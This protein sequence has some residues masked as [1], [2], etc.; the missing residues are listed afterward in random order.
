MAQENSIPENDK[1]T[2]IQLYLN[3]NIGEIIHIGVNQAA[4]LASN[5]KITSEDCLKYD[6]EQEEMKSDKADIK[7]YIK[8]YVGNKGLLVY[9]NNPV[10]VER[11]N[12]GMQENVLDNVNC[13]GK[14]YFLLYYV[15][16]RTLRYVNR[17]VVD[18]SD[19]NLQSLFWL[20][21]AHGKGINA[22]TVIHEAT[23]NEREIT[24]GIKEK[25]ERNVFDVAGLWT[26]VFRS[27]DTDGFYRQLEA[28]YEGLERHSKLIISEHNYWEEEV[29]FNLAFSDNA[30]TELSDFLNK[31]KMEKQKMLESY[32]R[33]CFLNQMLCYNKLYLYLRKGNMTGTN[34]Q[35]K[36]YTSKWDFEAV[37]ALSNYLSKRTLIGEYRL[38]NVIDKNDGLKRNGHIQEAPESVNF[39][40]I[41]QDAKPLKEDYVMTRNEKLVG[42]KIHTKWEFPG[43]QKMCKENGGKD[44]CNF[45]YKGYVRESNDVEMNSEVIA[46]Q[47]TSL[48][49]ASCTNC[50]KKSYT[51]KHYE[52]P[53]EDIIKK[54][55]K[56]ECE[57]SSGEHIELGQLILWREQP[58][59]N[60]ERSYF[61][62]ELNGT[63]GPATLALATIFI[64]EEQKI[65]HLSNIDAT[66]NTDSYVLC[67]LQGVIRGQLINKF[68]E[69][70]EQKA[71]GINTTDV[72]EHEDVFNTY[73]KLVLY[74]TQNYL[75]TILYHHF[76]PFLSIQ[77]IECI[78]NSMEYFIKSMKAESRSPF[79]LD[80]EAWRSRTNDNVVCNDTVNKVIEIIPEALLSVLNSFKGVEAFYEV[81]VAHK[82]MSKEVQMEDTRELL[83]I[84]E[85][86]KVKAVNCLF[87]S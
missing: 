31:R 83:D 59:N 2:K 74:A 19:N 41:G 56:E 28:V 47:H 38:C 69:E 26:A 60:K 37:S 65:E 51:V 86:N 73:M 82:K 14:K 8:G 39:I 49:C 63:S 50:G 22:I 34:N 58:E 36:G 40:C 33:N 9:P 87:S 7:R 67:K 54:F 32:Y 72:K 76:L 25:K 16:L 10:F 62:V 57:V 61:Q 44:E 46:T 18:I 24:T 79:S 77:D 64:N 6:F 80:Y 71:N 70:L 48:Q 75:S 45:I 4:Y 78:K 43:E 35:P 29:D 21:V 27:N 84:C 85:L 3:Y 42:H 30:E 55:Q 20:G 1:D 12:K 17:I 5:K 68:K 53:K 13:G 52:L 11:I 66:Y 15:V 81:K 23:E